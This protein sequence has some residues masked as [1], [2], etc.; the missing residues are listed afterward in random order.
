MG[1]GKI[2]CGRCGARVTT[3]ALGRAAHM[4]SAA[5]DRRIAVWCRTA[6]DAQSYIDRYALALDTV[7]LRVA[8][9]PASVR[10]YGYGVKASDGRWL[11][12]DGFLTARTS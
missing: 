6:D 12:S 7:T 10:K 5:C 4:R 2:I 8:P 3:N 9:Y 1:Y 11:T